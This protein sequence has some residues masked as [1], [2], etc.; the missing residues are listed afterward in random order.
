VR[1]R[2]FVVLIGSAVTV[3]FLRM[4]V[5]GAQEPGRVYRLGLI[6]GSAREAPRTLALIDELKA[7]GF[8][9]GQNLRIINDG[10]GL[11]AEQFAKV[12]ATLAQST[13][14]VIFCVGNPAMRA[15]Q[16]STPART[17]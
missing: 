14:D 11:R 15:A 10:F 2:E 17:S 8:V 1:R 16:E 9:E 3:P 4:I 5:A 7:S 6:S 12:A 13:P